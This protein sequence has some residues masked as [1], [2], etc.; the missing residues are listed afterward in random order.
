M[1]RVSPSQIKV[2]K[3]CPR[4]YVYEYVEGLRGAS[5]LAQQFGLEGHRY[6][7]NWLLEGRLPP[8]SAAGQVALQGIQSTAL[9]K[10]GS[11]YLIEQEM[12]IPLS[13]DVSLYGRIDCVELGD[14]PTI[15]DH[16]FTTSKKWVMTVDQLVLDPQAIIYA[17]WAMLE[18]NVNVVNLK[19]IYYIYT[20]T[21][22]KPNGL[23]VVS[24]RL[25]AND[26]K[27]QARIQAIEDVVEDM[28]LIR[29]CEP[30]ALSF[31]GEYTS[32]EMYGGCPH[33]HRCFGP[34]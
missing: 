5:T 26:P 2:F 31:D 7:E 1:L 13:L 30:D 8:Q 9:P 20:K 33:Q 29:E 25:Q 34:R 18:Y 32:C 17:S 4:R 11:N 23:E 21:L 22:K 10:L 6:L 28:V 14:I 3:N 15:I 27:Y 12:L 19:W 24:C 16:K